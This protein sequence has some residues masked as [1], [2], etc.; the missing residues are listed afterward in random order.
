FQVID[1]GAGKLWMSGPMGL[2]AVSFAD[3]NAV[4]DGALPALS[5]LVYGAGDGLESTQINGGV[6]L[7]GCVAANGELWFPSVKGAVHFQP[8]NPRIDQ[9]PP[10]RIETVLVDGRA[11]SASGDI[12]IGPNPRRVEIEFTS[13]TLRAPERVAF[14]YRLEG[15]DT[16]W[17][18]ATNR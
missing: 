7:A 10:V 15:I 11:V 13:S 9:Y 3:L 5:T 6:Q 2:S 16:R 8:G 17:I 1:D 14:R 4:A 12:V 18:A